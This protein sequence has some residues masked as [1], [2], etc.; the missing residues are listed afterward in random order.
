LAKLQT[1]VFVVYQYSAST[2]TE[3]AKERAFRGTVSLNHLAIRLGG[4]NTA[5]SYKKIF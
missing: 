3:R 5:C 1:N 4:L 2:G